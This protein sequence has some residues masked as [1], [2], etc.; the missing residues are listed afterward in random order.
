MIII[1]YYLTSAWLDDEDDQD[2]TDEGAVGKRNWLSSLGNYL[3]KALK[4]GVK[5]GDELTSVVDLSVSLPVAIGGCKTLYP[6]IQTNWDR[7]KELDREFQKLSKKIDELSRDGK[8]KHGVQYFVEK[9][10][11]EMSLPTA[12]CKNGYRMSGKHTVLSYGTVMVQ[13]A[14]TLK[15]LPLRMVIV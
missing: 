7:V 14:V 10:E 12:A 6:S 13:H 4:F 11:R 5:Y 9:S 15:W 3:F 2:V 8:N 1:N